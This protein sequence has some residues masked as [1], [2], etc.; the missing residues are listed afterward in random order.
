MMKTKT[1]VAALCVAAVS[2]VSCQQQVGDLTMTDLKIADQNIPGTYAC[3]FAVGDQL[4]M[5]VYEYVL[6]EDGTGTYTVVSW[7]DG[8]DKAT[9]TVNFSWKRG[10][11]AEDKLSIPLTFTFPDKT[12]VVTW[13]NGTIVDDIVTCGESAKATNYEKVID[14]L[15]N[16][17]WKSVDTTWFIRMLKLDSIKYEWKNQRDTLTQLEIDSVNLVLKANDKDTIAKENQKDLGNGTFQVIFPHYIGTV[18]NYEKPDTMH[19]QSQLFSTL[20][21]KRT[22]KTNTATYVYQYIEYKMSSDSTSFRQIKD[23][24]VNVAGNWFVPSLINAKK[25]Y[26]DIANNDTVADLLLSSY[27]KAKGTMECGGNKYKMVH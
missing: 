21:I 12:Q 2:F 9:S 4:N 15:P 19:V 17:S 23:E 8:M 27:D 1:L 14:L 20:D 3:Q 24:S 7:G 11:L 10:E 18:V 13:T 6:A 25:F 26:I 16:T 5:T 22:A